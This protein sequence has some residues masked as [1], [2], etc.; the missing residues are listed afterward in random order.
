MKWITKE[1][2]A[3]YNVEKS[4][5]TYNRSESSKIQVIAEPLQSDESARRFSRGTGAIRA[6]RVLRG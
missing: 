1:V 5:L 3:R 2:Y 6:L 4:P